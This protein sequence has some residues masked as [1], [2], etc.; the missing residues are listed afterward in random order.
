M[1]NPKAILFFGALVPQ[2]LDTHAPLLI[3]YVIMYAV[4]FIG[5]A[6]IL[7][8]YGALAAMGGRSAGLRHAVWRERV[9]GLVLL[10]LGVLAA[11]YSA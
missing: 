2:F 9:S 1:G 6:V 3:Q 10:S 5:E 4:T 7:T 8:G 11:L